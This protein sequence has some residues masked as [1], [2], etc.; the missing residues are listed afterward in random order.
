MELPVFQ[1]VPVAPCPVAEKS[2]LSLLMLTLEI[3]AH[4]GKI[5]SQPSLL[6]AKQAHL[7]QPFLTRE[8]Q[9]NE[10]EMATHLGKIRMISYLVRWKHSSPTPC[11]CLDRVCTQY[12]RWNDITALKSV[13]SDKF[14]D[15]T[16][17]CRNQSSS[18]GCST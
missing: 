14:K 2:G 7:S 17:S 5:S 9:N 18:A 3:S 15:S 16:L 6:Q 8:M 1:L 11:E 4:I 13:P 12:T 10:E